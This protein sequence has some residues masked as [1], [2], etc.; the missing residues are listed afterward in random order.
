[1]VGQVDSSNHKSIKVLI[2]V[3]REITIRGMIR[4]GT[5]QIIDQTV[6]AED[7]TDKTEVGLGMNKVIGEVTLD[8]M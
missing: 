3:R 8:E 2:E 1:M 7:N 5:D 4:R 6:V